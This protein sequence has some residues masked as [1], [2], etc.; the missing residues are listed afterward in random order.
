MGRRRSDPDVSGILVVDKPVGMTSHDV[1]AVVRRALGMRRVGHTGT[2][3]PAASG[4]LVCA[5]GRAT[6][7]VP[8]LQAG[9]KTYAATIV[10][11]RETDSQDAD[12]EV[13]AEVDASHLDEDTVC[14]ALKAFMGT[15]QQVPPMVSALKVGGE[16]LHEKARRGEVVER[17]PRTVTISDLVLEDFTPGERAEVRVLVTCS[18][19]TYVRT[20]AHDLGRALGVG[21][22]LSHLRRLANGGF[23][24]DEAMSLDEVRERGEAHDLRD[25]LLPPVASL[26]LLVQVDVDRDLALALAHGKHRDARGVEGPYAL[27]HDG[28]LVGVFHDEDDR[29]RSDVV[30]L[31][32]QDLEPA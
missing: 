31:R 32:P 13:V 25:R 2:L 28:R 10:L 6:R 20:I 16:R 1:V 12:G 4:V 18:P 8:Y 27:V 21:G 24:V 11:G 5:V 19:G 15:I 29:M 23:G 17:E 30:M 9:D 7:L 3:D 22:S 14:R 26:R